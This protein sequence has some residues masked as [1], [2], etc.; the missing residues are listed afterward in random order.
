MQ[1]YEKVLKSLLQRIRIYNQDIGREFG[2]EIWAMLIM[3]S[4]KRQKNGSSKTAKIKKQSEHL[5]I[6]K[7]ASTW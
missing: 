7:I 6:R 3:R 2:I 1:K 5:E 4:G